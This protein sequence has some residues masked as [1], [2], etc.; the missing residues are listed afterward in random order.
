MNEFSK[1]NQE[2]IRLIDEWE[3]K[4]SQLPEDIL[5]K[6]K[7]SQNR[8][9]KQIVGH[10]IDSASNNTHRIIHL[11]Y[12]ASPLIFPDYANLGNND[13]WI[14]IQ[15]Y[16]DEKWGDLVQLWKYSNYHIV[17][18]INNVNMEKL[19]NIWISAL[20]DA[21]SLKSMMID[22]LRHFRLHLSEIDDLINNK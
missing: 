12:Q 22:Y 5:T 3:P 9:I 15:N 14:V 18:V 16:Q 8:T 13:R 2:L 6:R 11:Q 4:L 1:N 19:D 21:V 7:N 10:M 20:N 17:H